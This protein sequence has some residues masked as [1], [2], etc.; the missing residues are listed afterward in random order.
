M[1]AIAD[2]Q[3]M[4]GCCS[5]DCGGER[6]R[7]LWPN[8]VLTQQAAPCTHVL[9]LPGEIVKPPWDCRGDER[10]LAMHLMLDSAVAI[11]SRRLLYCHRLLCRRLRSPIFRFVSLRLAILTRRC[12]Q[13]SGMKLESLFVK[14]TTFVDVKSG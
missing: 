10:S 7:P 6:F 12:G 8:R 13:L 14:S 5:R 9:I 4:N 2:V 3:L 1:A 11:A